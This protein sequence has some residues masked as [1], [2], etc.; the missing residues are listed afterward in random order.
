MK[1]LI[2]SHFTT[3]HFVEAIAPYLHR[4]VLVDAYKVSK[5]QTVFLFDGAQGPFHLLTYFSGHNAFFWTQKEYGKPRSKYN[6][7]FKS[8]FGSEVQ[9]ITPFYQERSFG[10]CFEERNILFAL[11]GRSNHIVPAD[12][13]AIEDGMWVTTLPSGNE[14]NFKESTDLQ[15][16]DDFV[17]KVLGKSIQEEALPKALEGIRKGNFSL[18]RNAKEQVVFNYGVADAFWTGDNVLE[19]LFKYSKTWFKEFHFSHT[20]Q[21]IEKHLEKEKK[22]LEKGYKAAEQQIDRIENELNYRMWADLLMAN[23]HQLS[24]GEKSVTLPDFYG[25][26]MVKIPLKPKQNIQENA[27]SYYRKAKNQSKEQEVLEQRMERFLEQMERIENQLERLSELTEIKPLLAMDKELFDKDT[28]QKKKQDSDFVEFEIDGFRIYV[29]RNSKNNDLLTQG[30]ASKN[31]LWMHAKDLAGSH[32][33]IRNKGSETK[34]PKYVIE[35]AAEI[36]AHFSKGRNQEFCP[37]LYT[38]KKYVRKPKGAPAGAVLVDRED[39]VLVRPGLPKN[40][41]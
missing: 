14:T 27:A 26:A 6:T 21:K 31:D 15:A 18:A 8:F 20:Y 23:L 9:R 5:E 12:Q 41:S 29:G 11:Y 30:F 37:V 13:A 40:N 16:D 17:K 22:R 19:A 7:V 10:I 24:G 4:A 25:T 2:L 39:V 38:P 33:V 36:A 3:W 34:F 1:D 35:Q 32:V 28:P